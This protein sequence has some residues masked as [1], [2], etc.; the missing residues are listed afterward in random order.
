[1][2]LEDGSSLYLE[3]ENKMYVAL[4]VGCLVSEDPKPSDCMNISSGTFFRTVE[5][6]EL[7]AV[8]EGQDFMISRG[9]FL[10]EIECVPTDV[11]GVGDV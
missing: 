3:K 1:M 11:F 10:M 8:T 4:L 2:R 5:E 6:C 7:S 9:M